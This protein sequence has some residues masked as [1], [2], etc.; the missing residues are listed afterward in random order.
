MRASPGAI[1]VDPEGNDLAG[2]VETMS[3]ADFKDTNINAINQRVHLSF[4]TA[5]RTRTIS[6]ILMLCGGTASGAT[7]TL[8]RA[9]FY[10]VGPSGDLSLACAIASDPTLFA[11][12]FT[13]YARALSTGGGLPPTFTFTAGQRYAGALLAVSAAAMP[14]FYGNSS[15]TV[16][17]WR[18]PRITAAL[19]GQADLPA[20]IAAVSLA[21][22]TARL[23]MAGLA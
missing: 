23:W 6:Q 21:T 19:D 10:V 22:S 9:G 13:E 20:A 15:G 5:K 7:P 3:R 18:A 14:G 2:A 11:A 12:T 1:G 16:P 4:F 17:W 8:Q